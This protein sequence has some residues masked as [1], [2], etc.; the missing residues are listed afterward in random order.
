[1]KTL[2]ITAVAL[3]LV[4]C[5]PNYANGSRVGVVTK[6]SNKGLVFKSWEGA[7]NQGGT[8]NSTD[9]DGNS[10]VVANVIEFSVT[11]ETLVPKLQEAMNNGKRVEVVYQQWFLKP[12]TIDRSRV[13]TAIKNAK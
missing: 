8:V 2:L 1:M 7:I 10:T 4:A 9:S 12:P 6:L 5:A 3:A 11:D 13:V